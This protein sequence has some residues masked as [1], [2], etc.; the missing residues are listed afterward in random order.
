MT[1][2]DTWEPTDAQ[3][4]TVGELQLQERS[5]LRRVVGLST[6]LDDV[7]EVEDRQLR[8]EQVVLVEE[9]AKA[10]VPATTTATNASASASL[11]IV[12]T[13]RRLMRWPSVPRPY[14]S[15]AKMASRQAFASNFA[16]PRSNGVLSPDAAAE[17]PPPAAAAGTTPKRSSHASARG[18]RPGS[19]DT[20]HWWRW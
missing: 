18:I 7:T 5:S 1:Q 19:P 17:D 4:P 12:F 6:E 10:G 13:N 11:G 8:L 16:S 3:Q 2:T 9:L 20:R 14:S 15:Y